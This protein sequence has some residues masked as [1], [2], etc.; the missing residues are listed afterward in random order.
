MVLATTV[1]VE[2]VK[3]RSVEIRHAVEAFLYTLGLQPL[4]IQLEVFTTKS[5]DFGDPRPAA[6]CWNFQNG[7]ERRCI[8]LPTSTG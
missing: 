2:R 1:P 8:R 7:A 3:N 6:R 5:M 4:S